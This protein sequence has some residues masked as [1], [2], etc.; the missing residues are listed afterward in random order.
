MYL[1][2][3]GIVLRVASVVYRI[4]ADEVETYSARTSK[5]CITRYSTFSRGSPHML[6]WPSERINNVHLQSLDLPNDVPLLTRPSRK[7]M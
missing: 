5:L 4:L 7:H 6:S 1:V 2:T 3:Y